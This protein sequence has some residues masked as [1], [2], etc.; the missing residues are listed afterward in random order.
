MALVWDRSMAVGVKVVD[1][2]HQ[3]LFRQVN[4]LVDAMMKGEGK[5]EIGSLL[6]FLG[7]YVVD[8]FGM[9]ERLMAQYRYPDAAAHKKA[10]ADFVAVFSKAKADFDAQG[11]TSPLTILLNKT[12]AEWL[13][14]HIAGTDLKLGRYLA[15]QGAQ[16]AMVR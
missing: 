10:H 5:A 6:G 8:H 16:E 11:A 13:R 4:R 7:K 9:E 2:Q 1:E 3:E 14:Q 15:A 12:V